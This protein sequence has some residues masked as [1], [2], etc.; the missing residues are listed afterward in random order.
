MNAFDRAVKFVLDHEG[1]VADDPLD[2]GGLTKWGI[3]QASYPT[4]DIRSLTREDARQ[5]YY[6]DYWLKCKCSELPAPLSLLLFDGAVNQ[7]PSAA[8]RMLQRALGVRP[9]GVI[10]PETIAAGHRANP[11]D[12]V[13]ELAA[14]R[15]QQYALHP[16][17]EH[18]GLG[19]YRRLLVCLQ[20]A[21]EP[22]G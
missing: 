7:G 20:V 2:S 3:S 22:L 18:F 19:W 17:V 10:G 4:L 15:A 11:R 1:G 6:N 8:V 14:R 13:Q 5:I 16:E 21:N 9:D 12:A